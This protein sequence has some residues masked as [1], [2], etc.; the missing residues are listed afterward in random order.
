MKILSVVGARPNFM[1]LASIDKAIKKHNSQEN[2]KT[3]EHVIVHTGQHYDERMSVCFFDEL[4]IPRPNT[5][6][7]VGSSSHAAQTA[8]IMELFE[9]VLLNEK[10]DV[11]LVVGDVNSTIATTL[12][13]SK[14]EYNDSDKRRPL[15][16]HVEAGLR[17]YDKDMPEEVNRI[18]TDNLSDILFTTEETALENL[19]K[20]GFSP[21]RVQ[22]VGNTMIDTL[23][24]NKDKALRLN[25]LSNILE[26][27]ASLKGSG[28][29][30][31]A[32]LQAGAP[33][34]V[35]TL[36][37]PSNVD[38]ADSLGA[39]V[40]CLNKISSKLTLIF[41][42]HPRTRNKLEN[43]NLY[44]S[45]SENQNIILTKP[46]G[47]LEFLSLLISSALVLT[48]SGGIQ[49]ETTYLK[50]PCVTLRENTERPV[51]VKMGTNYLV[52]TDTS[53]ILETALSIIDG[54]GKE[55]EIPPLWDGNAGARI[56]DIL[57][58]IVQE[59][60]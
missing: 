10:P 14:I 34:G 29:D 26:N 46:A 8:Q 42:L 60:R 30:I 16:V 2:K 17:S 21:D 20:E 51:T 37:R 40:E 47:Y 18:L 56:V 58:N 22:F 3:I 6:L 36:H 19:T 4:E 24:S 23:I 15:I 59:G 55:G 57:M 28:S 9:P 52:G 53:N 45:L 12:V 44:D 11:L 1:K 5:N 43:F 35:V 38:D 25:A 13:A 41:P 33:Y 32:K 48:D 49:E 31:A 50:V 54:K 39:L 7:E 27:D